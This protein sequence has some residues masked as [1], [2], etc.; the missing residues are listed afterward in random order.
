MKNN[1]HFISS[2]K[3]SILF[4][5]LILGFA[6]TKAQLFTRPLPKKWVAKADCIERKM[7][8][9][10]G[11]KAQNVKSKEEILKRIVGSS[12]ESKIFYPIHSITTLLNNLDAKDP[13]LKGVNIYITS[14]DITKPGPLRNTNTIDRQIVLVFATA[15][16]DNGHDDT[17]YYFAIGADNSCHEIT[18]NDK[19]NWLKNYRDN[20][21]NSVNG[22]N[23]TIDP[24]ASY[25]WYQGNRLQVSDTWRVF[26][27]YLELKEFLVDEKDYQKRKFKNDLYGIQV[28]FS[29]YT[30]LG[31]DE[32]KYKY[33]LTLQFEYT[34]QKND[35]TYEVFYLDD[36]PN[37]FRR[38]KKADKQG[39]REL[40]RSEK[41]NKQKNQKNGEEKAMGFNH[42]ELCPD[43]CN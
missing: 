41:Q 24:G 42:G 23:T 34:R 15:R 16:P 27:D 39:R 38:K 10:F 29:S 8:F 26:H 2:I 14:F 1:A 25:N 11:R 6:E 22:F 33:R 18:M 13:N 37:F 43:I 4:V 7:W 35:G 31:N 9:R 40:A 36:Q 30:E 28:D 32:G 5:L 21:V 20:I 12:Q 3:M 17:G 19:D